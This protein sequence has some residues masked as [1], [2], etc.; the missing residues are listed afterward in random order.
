MIKS[1]FINIKGSLTYVITYGKWIDETF[2]IA[3]GDNEV[4]ILIPG[5]PG[6]AEFYQT[7]A[8]RLYENTKIPVWVISKYF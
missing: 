6:F 7:F 8:K 5:N 3:N 2:D 4:I 1:N